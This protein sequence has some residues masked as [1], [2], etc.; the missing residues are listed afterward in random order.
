MTARQV[1]AEKELV[2]LVYLG[3]VRSHEGIRLWRR[4]QEQ[5]KSPRPRPRSPQLEATGGGAAA[6][7]IGTGPDEAT[8][9]RVLDALHEAYRRLT[10]PEQV[11]L[12]WSQ[13]RWAMLSQVLAKLRTLANVAKWTV[14]APAQLLSSDPKAM[15][16][17]GLEDVSLAGQAVDTAEALVD[18][19]LL[20]IAVKLLGLNGAKK[21]GHGI[22]AKTPAASWVSPEVISLAG[23]ALTHLRS[24]SLVLEQPR[25]ST[26]RMDVASL[27]QIYSGL[28]SG[29]ASLRRRLGTE[30]QRVLQASQDPLHA[31]AMAASSLGVTQSAHSGQ[32][33]ASVK[34]KFAVHARSEEEKKALKADS[35]ARLHQATL[36]TSISSFAEL[37]VGGESEGIE[38]HTE[39]R[40]QRLLDSILTE[41]EKP[42]QWS[43]AEPEDGESLAPWRVE[44]TST[45]L[46][47]MQD[48]VA[49]GIPKERAKSREQDSRP[50]SRAQKGGK[51]L[52]FVAALSATAEANSEKQ[53]E[54][55][56]SIVTPD[57]PREASRPATTATSMSFVSL[58]TNLTD[59][60]HKAQA[61]QKKQADQAQQMKEAERDWS[62]PIP[63]VYLARMRVDLGVKSC[64][65]LKVVSQES[66]VPPSPAAVPMP[67]VH[68]FVQTSPTVE[69][70]PVEQIEVS[71]VAL[72]HEVKHAEK[73]VREND[74][75]QMGGVPGFAVKE[76][77]MQ[78][79]A[80]E[81]EEKIRQPDTRDLPPSEQ[82]NDEGRHEQ[83]MAQEQ[84]QEALEETSHIVKPDM[85]QDHMTIQVMT[86]N[87]FPM[88]LDVPRNCKAYQVAKAEE[89]LQTMSQPIAVADMMGCYIPP[90]ETLHEG[91]M[92]RV[93]EGGLNPSKCPRVG[94]TVKP[95]SVNASRK[96]ILWKQEGWTEWEEMKFYA[97]LIEAVQP[98]SV[99]VGIHIPEDPT[100][101]I[102]L[103]QH[104]KNMMQWGA[105]QSQSRIVSYFLYKDHWVPLCVEIGQTCVVYTTPMEITWVR[106][107]CQNVWGYTDIQFASHP[108][109]SMFPADCGFQTIGWMNSMI[110]REPTMTPVGILV[111]CAWRQLFSDHLDLTGQADQVVKHKLIFGGMQT[112]QDE[113]QR[114]VETHGVASQRSQSCAKEL[115]EALGLSSIQN[116]LHSQKPWADLK[117]RARLHR[118]PIRVVM[119]SEL[120]ESIKQ[121]KA[122]GVI[123]NKSS[124]KKSQM[125]QESFV[126]QASQL[127]IPKAVFKQSDDV[128]LGQLM[129]HQ[130]GAGCQG[131]L[132][133]NIQ[134]ALPFFALSNPVTVEGTALLVIEHADSRIPPNREII[135]VP[136]QCKATEEPVIVTVAML[137]IGQKTVMRNTPSQWVAIKEVENKAIRVLVFR[138]QFQ[139]QWQDI[140]DKPVKSILAMEPFVS[141]AAHNILDVWDRQ[142]TS[143]RMSK[144]APKDAEVFLVN[145][146]VTNDVIQVLMGAS[147][148]EG[149][150]VEPRSHN[151]RQ[152]D[153]EQQIV[154]LPRKSFAEA[155]IARQ[156][157]PV[158][159]VLARSGDKYGLRVPVGDAEKVHTMHRPDLIF[160]QGGELKKFRVGPLPYGSTK[161]SIVNAFQKWGWQAR[162]ISPCGQSQD[163]TG[164]MWFVQSSEPPAF[165]VFQMQHGDVLVTPESQNGNPTTNT[166]GGIIASSKTIQCLRD[167]KG[168]IHAKVE[169]QEDPW[170]HYDPWQ[171]NT[172]EVSVGQVLSLQSQLEA[173]IDKKMA[174][175]GNTR[176]ED[177]NSE[178]IMQL[179]NQVQQMSASVQA[180]Q[181]QQTQHTQNLYG[182]VQSLDK[183][184]NEQHQSLNNMLDSKLDS[185]MQKIEM[186]LTK[187]PVTKAE[188]VCGKSGG[189]ARDIPLFQGNLGIAGNI[190]HTKNGY[191][192]EV[193][194]TISTMAPEV[195]TK[196]Y[197]EKCD[198]W[199]LGVTLYICSIC[200]EPWV[201]DRTRY[202]DEKEIMR[203]LQDPNFEIPFGDRRFDYRSKPNVDLVKTML[204]RNPQNRPRARELLAKNSYA[205]AGRPAKGCCS[206]LR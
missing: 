5:R 40:V 105:Q 141:L 92:I 204:T 154:W 111:A 117:A 58:I 157:T 32:K 125:H 99:L 162:P 36:L 78:D 30:A 147:G 90:T 181:Q 193:V 81:K 12:Y 23:M 76:A 101:P 158:N 151:G 33:W 170:R 153:S 106:E 56:S 188:K 136:A 48:A 137:Q 18:A 130:I 156:T 88:P 108:I 194:G 203:A 34:E 77:K 85:E 113:L 20:R 43:E 149:L 179:E 184:L 7:A 140:V 135:R 51:R 9:S 189:L 192:T 128:E 173:T 116:I 176:M 98:N 143:L 123:G 160:M 202:M 66:A 112:A 70:P 14:A 195:F 206:C 67:R 41:N 10:R 11:G 185:Q 68:H 164:V 199:S 17:T 80:P 100:G 63:D 52:S 159:T 28:A 71:D 168:P 96:D 152:P 177:D 42:S 37:G 169:P 127:E 198:V 167:V 49:S 134:D 84:P 107:S 61:S 205:R 35:F 97:S 59:S 190:Q 24:V 54:K 121:R 148:T 95:S 110:I 197:T 2:K 15:A 75:F 45:Q 74:D 83:T 161:Q 79:Q 65:T 86:E 171:K 93:Q 89:N 183:R 16:E 191:L 174:D 132:L 87:S 26:V 62:I 46:R 1:N 196:Q 60:S 145:M 21:S 69:Q 114:L 115:I 82:S 102:H 50:G 64:G 124:K 4:A 22:L 119:S 178:R 133:V 175:I 165:W 126:L 142:F 31:A 47:A 150:Y 139:G 138:D 163:Q 19:R 53:N 131:V 146:R 129:P 144:A 180:F 182:Q 187:R 29:L 57:A 6:A 103:G 27:E 186:L 8:L 118:P 166:P 73:R 109:S 72:L 44:F 172:K 104:L 13:E 122:A 200:Q 39:R 94:K 3:E 55:R 155:V 25:G 38:E 120:G 91:Q 201:F